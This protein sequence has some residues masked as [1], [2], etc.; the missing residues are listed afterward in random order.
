MQLSVSTFWFSLAQNCFVL[1]SLLGRNAPLNP[2]LLTPR[3]Q[4]ESGQPTS[5]LGW[6]GNLAVIPKNVLW[7][8]Q[9][10]LLSAPFLHKTTYLYSCNI[11]PWPHS[12]QVMLLNTLAYDLLPLLT[13]SPCPCLNEMEDEAMQEDLGHKPSIFTF[14]VLTELKKESYNWMKLHFFS[15]SSLNVECLQS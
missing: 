6:A 14:K 3:V 9:K 8:D 7:W 4:V 15:E 12:K 13:P 2:I 1:V 5:E 11:I 10:A